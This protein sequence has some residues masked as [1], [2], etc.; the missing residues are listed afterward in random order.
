MPVA[1]AVVAALTCQPREVERATAV[2]V[3]ERR[4]AEAQRARADLA[5]I[6]A[7]LARLSG[8]IAAGV[9]WMPWWR[10]CK[11]GRAAV[12]LSRGNWQPWSGRR[13]PWTLMCCEAA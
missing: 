9:P 10:P 1:E 5:G 4:E 3:E 2:L 6:E 8:A 11:T 12:K 7:E 13:W